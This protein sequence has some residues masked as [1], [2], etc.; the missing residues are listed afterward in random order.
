LLIGASAPIDFAKC[1]GQV[2]LLSILRISG[3]I[4]YLEFSW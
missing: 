1:Y 2:I 3:S 4:N